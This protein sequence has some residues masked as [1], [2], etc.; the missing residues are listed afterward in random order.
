MPADKLKRRVYGL[1]GYRGINAGKKLEI[2]FTVLVCFVR[3]LENE[4]AKK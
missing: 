3:R 4:K 1:K 2:L